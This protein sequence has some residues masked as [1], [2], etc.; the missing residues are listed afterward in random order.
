MNPIQNNILAKICRLTDTDGFAMY[1]PAAV[2]FAV[3]AGYV[4]CNNEIVDGENVAVRITDAGRAALGT[5]PAPQ[6]TQE[7]PSMDQF[8]IDDNVPMP[9][10]TRQRESN[11]PFDLLQ[12]EQSFFV[13]HTTDDDGELAPGIA[14]STI[15][16][17]SRRHAVP[18]GT[19]MV[20]RKNKE[21]GEMVPTEVPNYRY[22]RKFK[23]KV[24]VENE[25][26]GTRVW[27]IV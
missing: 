8:Q 18:D 17:A 26:K 16:T 15:S 21:T 14:A 11:F 25:I 13:P 3:D 27:R 10:D 20:N 24:V 19:K 7:A 22:D 12:P 1:K 4:E 23:G 6:P 5:E 2:Q 9:A